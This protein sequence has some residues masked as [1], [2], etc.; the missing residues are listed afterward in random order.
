[1]PYN[2]SDTS[3]SGV[4][5]THDSRYHFFFY[6]L[7]ILFTSRCQ[8]EWQLAEHFRVCLPASTWSCQSMT[9]IHSHCRSEAAPRWPADVWLSWKCSA[10]AGQ[11]RKGK[12]G[13]CLCV[14]GWRGS[15]W[16]SPSAASRGFYT[17]S[18]QKW[19]CHGS[20]HLLNNWNLGQW[21]IY[22]ISCRPYKHRPPYHF[23]GVVSR[24]LYFF[25]CEISLI[26]F[27]FI[28]LFLPLI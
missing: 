16:T 21:F 6:L 20:V 8:F 7:L 1:M 14:C 2:T 26:V 24:F 18:S 12:G 28:N 5:H 22:F 15:S 27:S 10:S 11:W 9:G 4:L 19:K 25:F 23:F 3:H 13:V 17:I